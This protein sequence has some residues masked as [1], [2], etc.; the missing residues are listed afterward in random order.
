VKNILIVDDDRSAR[1]L[2][3]D[4]LE[5]QGYKV[6]EAENGNSAIKLHQ[7]HPFDLIISDILMPDKDGLE[8]LMELKEKSKIIVL[9]GSPNHFSRAADALGALSVLKKPLNSKVLLDKIAEYI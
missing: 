2:L 7:Q 5:K 3:R 4:C 9:T 1:F 8:L 6:F